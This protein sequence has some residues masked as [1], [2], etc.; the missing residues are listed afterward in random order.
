[1]LRHETMKNK[2]SFL[3]LLLTEITSVCFIS[4]CVKD[5]AIPIHPSVNIS[6]QPNDTVCKG[7]AVTFIATT[8]A[9]RMPQFQWLYNGV[10]VASTTNDQY[11]VD[12]V[13][14]SDYVQ[15]VVIPSEKCCYS[16]DTSAK[17]MM[18]VYAAGNVIVP[19]AFSPN[20]NGK[21]D[22]LY[23]NVT[24]QNIE[25]FYMLIYDRWGEKMFETNN[26]SIGWDGTYKGI[27][28]NSAVFGYYLTAKFSCGDSIVKKGNLSLIR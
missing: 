22:T 8:S 3:I 12:S 14:Q 15:C 16:I 7:Q 18:K 2:L 13:T 21:D 28:H 5:R 4:S 9:G 26:A 11:T 10:V 24:G 17:I 23:V 20:V 6:V 25:S 1:M 27:L 19:N